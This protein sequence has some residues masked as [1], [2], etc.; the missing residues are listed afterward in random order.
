MG[1]LHSVSEAPNAPSAE[2]RTDSCA[3]TS[4]AV[5]D[6]PAVLRRHGRSFWLAG[7][8][9]PRTAA[10]E[11]AELY[12]FCRH[13]DDAADEAPDP[14]QAREALDRLEAEL[15]GKKKAGPA[16]APFLALAAKRGLPAAAARELLAGIRSDL[17]PV[18]IPDDAALFRYGWRVAGTVGLLM[19]GILGVSDPR[20][21][22]HAV[23]LGIAMQITNICRDVLE[24][25]RRGRVYLPATRLRAEGLRT[26]DLLDPSLPDDPHRRVALARV[27]RSL[28]DVADTFYARG[29]AGMP[30]IPARPRLAIAVAATLYRDIGQ[31]L[32]H[33]HGGD[34]CHGRTTVPTLGRALGF[35]RGIARFTDSFTQDPLFGSP[36]AHY[37]G[38]SHQP[39]FPPAPIG[40]A[41]QFPGAAAA[42]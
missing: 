9:L 8:L 14:A 13:L 29:W 10:A 37:A 35:V 24:D 2:T 36:A 4:A 32:R 20:A 23:D 42:G 27:V 16:V 34:P 38:L 6:A 28:L 17:G 39:G 3:E 31:R 40:E 41:P 22:P 21:L 18:R 5:V 1:Q 33:E 25:G 15:E 30:A 19:C 12:A 26:E 11:A 7:L